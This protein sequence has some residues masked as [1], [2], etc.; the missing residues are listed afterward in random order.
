MLKSLKL[1]FGRGET[2]VKYYFSLQYSAIQK[3][4]LRHDR[5]WSIAG[6][7]QILSELNEIKLPGIAR[8][9]NNDPS[10]ENIIVA[11]GGKFTAVFDAPEKADNAKRKIIRLISTT[12]PMLEFQASGVIEA[13]DFAEAKKEK[14][15]EGK[16]YPGIIEELSLAKKH[17]RGYGVT[18]NPHLKL[19][20]E[21]EEYPAVI[22]R[23]NP[24]NDKEYVCSVCD[25]SKRAA[26]I[27]IQALFD[28]HGN[29]KE[30]LTTI[31]KIY[32]LYIK[33][34]PDEPDK[35]S[36]PLDFDDL[37]PGKDDV[38]G[39]GRRIAVW[40]SDLNNMNS[41]V[42]LWLNQ[43]EADIFKTFQTVKE[44]N[45]DILVEALKET[46]GGNSLIRKKDKK[47]RDKTFVPFRLIVAGGDDLCI[48]MSDK[49]VM[50]FARKYSEA[51]KSG[52]DGLKGDH[53]LSSE[54]L[55][56][57]ADEYYKD[58]PEADKKEPGPY[59][60]GGSFVVTSVHTPFKKLH[61]IGD[62][63][64]KE[65]KEKTGRSWNGLN[66][67][68]MASDEGAVS[69][70]MMKFEKPVLVDN[71][72][73]KEKKTGHL[74]FSDYIDLCDKFN[75]MSNSQIQ[76]I[77]GKIMHEPDRTATWLKRHPDSRRKTTAIYKILDD[78]LL[79][80]GGRLLTGRLATLLELLSLSG[81]DKNNG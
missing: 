13:A 5:L 30:D 1:L 68:V 45:V 78:P 80:H 42:P 4:V 3:T 27:E 48:V 72:A 37:F 55:I 11:G 69:E 79:N 35:P 75:G 38:S 63:L 70:K 9:A 34:L 46:F 61:E 54:W 50:N 51:V 76:Q 7:S 39:K 67:L 52:I 21:C 15:I 2:I 22:D 64:M 8:A 16:D 43:D 12:L 29:P 44:K 18:F 33:N 71:P 17:L 31:R 74:Y 20:E 56:N 23:Y 73:G 14:K 26:G 32:A 24:D 10:T 81:G 58:K 66:W 60:F 57:K 25:L 28:K 59:C 6:I 41:K 40:F 65:A 47:G 36:A 62:E 53:P 19:C 77:A 49:Y